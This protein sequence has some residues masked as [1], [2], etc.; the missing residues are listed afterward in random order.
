[1]KTRIITS[2]SVA[3]GLAITAS[4]ANSA[5]IATNTQSVKDNGFLISTAA[6]NGVGQTNRAMSHLFIFSVQ[7]IIANEASISSIADFDT[8]TFNLT[9]V[10]DNALQLAGGATGEYVF[11][12]AGFFANGDTKAG[13]DL[14][15]SSLGQGG[16][17][18]EQ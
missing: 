18:L 17:F 12:Y 11:R 8:V 1:M 4:F 5:T 3:A 15:T 16:N 14:H 6:E 9:L 13:V 7:D 2:L 10:T